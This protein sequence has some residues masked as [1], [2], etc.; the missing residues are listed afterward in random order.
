MGQTWEDLLFAHWPVSED[1]LRAHVPASLSVDLHGGSAWLGVTPFRLSNF[2][3]RGILPIPGLN[4]FLELNVRTYVTAG[5]RPGIW[6]FSLD[7]SSQ[8]AVELARRTYK[9]PYFRARMSMTRRSDAIDY[10]C[11]RVDEPGRVFSGSYRPDGA[12]AAPALGSL[13]SF[14]VDRYCLYTTDDAGVLYRAEIHHEPWAL[15]PADAEID[16]VS[17]VPLELPDEPPLCHYSHRQ[18]VVIWPLEQV[19]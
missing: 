2:R 12:A 10:E 18:D 1:V 13:E 8:L 15:Q 17:I 4:G 5:D 6:F 14:L 19:V 3:L 16:L 9:L 11:A 7:A